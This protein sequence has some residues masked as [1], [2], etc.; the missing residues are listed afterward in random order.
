MQK[1][2]IPLLETGI[3][4]SRGGGLKGIEFL[5]LIERGGNP[6]PWSGNLVCS[7]GGPTNGAGP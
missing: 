4:P 3:G 7:E 5:W 2:K 6:H 1:E